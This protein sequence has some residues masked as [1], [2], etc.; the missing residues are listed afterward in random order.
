MNPKKS[1]NPRLSRLQASL[2]SSE[3]YLITSY[4]NYRYFSGFS[5]S[6]C[7]LIITNSEALLLT[8]GRYTEQAKTQAP[9][10]EIVLQKGS[11]NKLICEVVTEKNITSIGYETEKVSDF[12]IVA[13][14]ATLNIEWKPIPKFAEDF[15]I[16]KD[17]DEINSIRKAV[18]ISD[19][20]F[21]MLLPQIKVGMTEREVA[22]LLEYNMAILG[23]EHPAFET[24]AASG[25]RSSLPHGA[26]TDKK[27]SENELL[28]LDFG[29]CI[30]GYMSD[31]TRTIMIGTPDDKLV[32]LFNT[33]LDVQKRC[34]EAVKPNILAKELDLY[35]RKLF[36]DAGLSEYICHSLGHGVGLEIHEAP[37]VSY[38]SETKLLPGMVITIEPGLYIPNL[39]GVR[40]EDTILVTENGFERLTNTPHNIKL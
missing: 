24:I 29:A 1:A 22:A 27:L 16:L 7:A 37:T 3:A 23:S 40:T 21:E 38:R 34:V 30:N 14:K 15:R 32:N 39:G 19:K 25:I 5:G 20:A 17:E 18:E 36:E 35:E 11:L 2:Q 8:D 12:E 28:T 26:P 13:L 31:I 6:N 10:F 33:V 4:E 9:D